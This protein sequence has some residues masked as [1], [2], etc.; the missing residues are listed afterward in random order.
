MRQSTKTALIA[1]RRFRA[2]LP[3]RVVGKERCRFDNRLSLLL[4]SI[5]H[6]VRS[7]GFFALMRAVTGGVALACPGQD[8]GHESTR[9]REGSL[10]GVVRGF[11]NAFTRRAH[12]GDIEC[13]KE[14]RNSGFPE[15][16]QLT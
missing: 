5:R 10:S 13:R 15:G 16:A 8:E 1:T 14:F 2:F 11:L 3:C 9:C 4:A 6:S 7:L 12:R